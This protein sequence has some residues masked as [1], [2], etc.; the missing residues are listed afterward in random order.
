[1]I[2]IELNEI[3]YK[4]IKY[5][6]DQGKLKNFKE[7]FE[8]HIV[9]QT[10]SENNYSQLEPW[11]QWPSFYS[12]KS[13]C[14]HNCF[15][16]G[17]F[18]KYN[19][20]SIFSKIQDEGKSVLAVSPMNC[21]FEEK[22]SSIFLPDPWEDF[23]TKDKGFLSVLYKAIRDK[24]NTNATS[25]SKLSS[26]FILMLGLVRYARPKNYFK[27]LRFIFLSLQY[28]WYQAIILDLLLFDIFAKHHKKNKFAYSSIFLNAGAHIQHHYLFDS[29]C[30]E[31]NSRNPAGYSKASNTSADPIYEIFSLYND[32]VGEVLSL[33]SKF[34]VSTGLQQTENKKPY[35]QYMLSLVL[36]TMIINHF[37][38]FPR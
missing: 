14:D 10:S 11:I 36:L 37:Q 21:Y 29:K 26:Y 33:N 3:N 19:L 1:M 24:V 23:E 27:Y 2:S 25:N 35:C 30:Y 34:M 31:G 18:K 15:H 12:G 38:H 20:E 22:D 7:L 4:W 28:K 17:D 32:I 6:I 9:H 16:I 5:Y 13:F 8:R